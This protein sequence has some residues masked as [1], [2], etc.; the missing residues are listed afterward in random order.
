LFANQ[1]TTG[2]L[3]VFTTHGR[4]FADAFAANDTLPNFNMSP[5]ARAE[6][7]ADYNNRGFGYQPYATTPEYG[8]SIASPSWVVSMLAD[9]TPELRLVSYTERAWRG[10]HDVVTCQKGYT[11]RVPADAA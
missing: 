8:L 7:L 1:L 10:R 4:Y 3:L 9:C 11:R 2:G 5:A 6:M